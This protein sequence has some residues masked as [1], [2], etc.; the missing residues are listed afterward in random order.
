MRHEID[1]RDLELSETK[2]RLRKR[3]DELRDLKENLNKQI[4]L[5]DHEYRG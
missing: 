4:G 1:K 3:E 2:E 5:V